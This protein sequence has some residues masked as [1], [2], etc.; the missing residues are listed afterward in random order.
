MSAATRNSRL[1]ITFWCFRKN[2]PKLFRHG[3]Y[4]VKIAARQNFGFAFFK[5][6]F[7]LRAV[8]FRARSV[9]AAVGTARNRCHNR[10]TESVARPSA[11]VWH[12]AM[13]CNALRCDGRMASRYFSRYWSPNCRTTIGQLDGVFLVVTH[14]R[15]S[16]S[17]KPLKNLF[18]SVRMFSRTGSVK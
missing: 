6:L 9:A 11:F 12:A 17:N 18:N 7:D 3:N 15:T 16:P 1:Y 8:T 10:C 14:D 13:S 4:R 2:R 5:P